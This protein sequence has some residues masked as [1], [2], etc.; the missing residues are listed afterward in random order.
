[1]K[2][3][4]TNLAVAATCLLALGSSISSSHAATLVSYEF[5]DNDVTQT[6]GTATGSDVS[7][8]SFTG[9]GAGGTLGTSSASDSLYVRTSATGAAA[10]DADTLAKAIT[11]NNYAT[12]TLTNTTGETVDL[13]NLTFDIYF[14][15]GG[16]TNTYGLYVMSDA[17]AFT[18]GNELGSVVYDT[19]VSAAPATATQITT[20]LS[21][22]ADLATSD[23]IDFRIYFVDNIDSVDPI[24]RV[25]NITVNGD[26][27]AVPEPSSTVLLG[28]GGL[29]L[30]LR[31][32]K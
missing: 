6:T 9:G 31:R 10:A 23:T 16:T 25:D 15:A 17:A 27:A 3:Q 30:I 20:G 11:L 18:A 26:V 1:M 14:T 22:L 13:T 28:L 12:F 5:L 24:F 8:G 32:R 21:G 2:H 29:A 7:Y 19:T 4:N